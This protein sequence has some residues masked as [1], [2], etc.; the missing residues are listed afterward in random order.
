M[1]RVIRG[2]IVE[3]DVDVIV[4]SAHPT[5]MAGSGVC[6]AIHA[7]AGPML[8]PVVKKLGPLEPGNAVTTE[9]Y[10]LNA[11]HIIHAVAP[12]Y[13]R[14][15]TEEELQLQE[16]YKASMKEFQK[17]DNAK[18]IAFPSMGTGI[19]GWPLDLAAKIA[20]ETLSSYPNAEIIICAFDANTKAAY[21]SAIEN[22]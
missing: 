12:R 14:K 19:Y 10:N 17:L 20:A 2:N 15:T 11:S 8:E 13:L 3:L 9:S 5:L 18:T 7:A 1:I 22:H 4:N 16:T 6:G 21:L